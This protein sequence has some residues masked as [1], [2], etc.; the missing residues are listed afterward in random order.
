M[1]KKQLCEDEASDRAVEEKVVPLD[2]GPDRGGD[3]GAAKL[4]LMF[5]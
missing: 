5:G 2:R 3:D 4:N 1:R